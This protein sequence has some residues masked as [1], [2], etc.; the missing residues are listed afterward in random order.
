MSPNILIIVIEW[1][2]T[3]GESQFVTPHLKLLQNGSHER[4][5][6]SCRTCD[7]QFVSPNLINCHKMGSLEWGVT[8]CR[9]WESQIVSHELGV[10]ICDFPLSD[11]LSENGSHEWG[12]TNGESQ[13]AGRVAAE[14]AIEL[15][16]F[17]GVTGASA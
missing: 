9:T 3:S 10:P 7:S 12:V 5:V 13:V 6:T 1:E 14:T 2:V 8:F 17:G 16:V 11:V 15:E 4:G